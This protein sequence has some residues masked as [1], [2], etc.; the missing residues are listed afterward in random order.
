MEKKGV[1]N[2]WRSIL[3][4]VLQE[5]VCLGFNK[6]MEIPA[7]YLIRMMERKCRCFILIVFWIVFILF[8]VILILLWAFDDHMGSYIYSTIGNEGKFF[9]INQPRN[10]VVYPYPF[11]L[12]SYN[13]LI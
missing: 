2:K 11:Y 6:F 9:R 1:V 13:N 10:A 3:I 8:K 7:G 5:R 4:N 12:R